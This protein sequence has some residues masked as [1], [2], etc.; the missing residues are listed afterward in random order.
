M[1]NQ[2]IIIASNGKT[3]HVMVNGKLYGDHIAGVK[4]SHKK[5]KR[6]RGDAELL[7]TSDITPIPEGNDEEKQGFMK[8]LEDFSR[9]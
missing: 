1:E 7:I 2:K 9:E 8:M 3:T 6:G 5:K 4:F